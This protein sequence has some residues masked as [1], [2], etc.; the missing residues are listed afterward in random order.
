MKLVEA[1]GYVTAKGLAHRAALT[2][3]GHPTGPKGG[4]FAVLPLVGE[5]G[6]MEL[7]PVELNNQTGG[8]EAIN[9]PLSPDDSSAG[10]WEC[11]PRI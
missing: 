6:H 3:E 10:D 8:F 11:F 4:L 5:T 2:R 9:E 1:V 7:Q